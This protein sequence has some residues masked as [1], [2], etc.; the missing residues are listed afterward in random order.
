MTAPASPVPNGSTIAS[1][2]YLVV[3]MG[4]VLESTDNVSLYDAGAL[5]VQGTVW[6]ALSAPGFMQC[7]ETSRE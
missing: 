5:Y 6:S 7:P 2:G 1:A 3:E 4:A